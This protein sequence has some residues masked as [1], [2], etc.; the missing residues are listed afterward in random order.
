MMKNYSVGRA[1]E[2]GWVELF[3]GIER[4]EL[5]SGKITLLTK[6]KLAEGK[7][8]PPHKHHQ[9]QT[10]YLISGHVIMTIDGK[11]NEFFPGDSWSIVSGTEHSAEA[12]RDTVVVESFT[13]VKD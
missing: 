7:I 8:L 11:K 5:V 12:L 4:K 3:E 9:E 2:N 6:I 1:S 13:P 10:G